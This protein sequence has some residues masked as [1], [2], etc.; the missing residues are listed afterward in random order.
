MI[1]SELLQKKRTAMDELA[2][3]LKM[4]PLQRRLLNY[5]E[6]DPHSKNP[7]TEKSL[8]ECY[9]RGAEKFGWAKRNPEP[10]SMKDGN[11]LIGWGMARETYPGRRMPA[12]ALVRL[13]PD[14][15][16][17]VAS[18]SQEIGNGTYTIMTQVPADVLGIPP[19]KI[20]AQLGDTNLPEAPISAGS[21]TTASVTP[22]GD[23]FGCA[24]E[25]D[26]HGCR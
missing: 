10:G 22:A 5:A 23:G 14:G 20:E 18:G 2:Y 3:K 24:L 6:V 21:M 1:E 7:F 4:D 13:Q 25:T 12:A 15:R 8:R 16:V 19:D 9:Q 26:Q 11:L 17:L